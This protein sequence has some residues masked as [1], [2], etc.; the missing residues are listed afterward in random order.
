L[1]F[2]RGSHVLDIARMATIPHGDAVL[3]MGFSSRSSAGPDFDA[4][5]PGDPNFNPQLDFSPLPVGVDSSLDGNSYLAP[6]KHFHSNPF[7]GN[8]PASVTGFPGFD[9]TQPLNLLK[10][11]LDPANPVVDM[12]TLVFSTKFKTGGI[13]NIPFVTHQ[14]N[15]TS[16]I[17]IFWIET[18]RDGTQQLQYAQKVMLEFFNAKSHTDSGLIQWPHI[19][20]N[21]LKLS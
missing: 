7:R 11:A 19:S 17:A 21:T 20:I 6:Y 1:K 8:V 18:L 9:P 5:L 2:G 13:H 12:T 16:M 10:L 4:L 3:A 15:A 14:A